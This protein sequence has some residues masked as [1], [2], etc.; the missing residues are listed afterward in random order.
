[1]ATG[2]S[3]VSVDALD[4]AIAAATGQL[5][6]DEQHLAVAV[7]WLLAGGAPVTIHCGGAG[8]TGE[9]SDTASV[10]LTPRLRWSMMRPM[11]SPVADVRL[12]AGLLPVFR[13]G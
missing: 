3:S 11:T 1:M 5:S 12:S 6:E 4:A 13:C 7:Y 9:S 2:T 10:T 8:G